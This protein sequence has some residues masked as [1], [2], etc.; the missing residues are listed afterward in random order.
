MHKHSP[1]VETSLLQI[2]N[3]G[4]I[5]L[6]NNIIV[7]KFHLSPVNYATETSLSFIFMFNGQ[8]NK[9]CFVSVMNML[10]IYLFAP[11]KLEKGHKKNYLAL[12]WKLCYTMV[13]YE[14]GWNIMRNGGLN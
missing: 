10:L 1:R 6:L 14:I 8:T 4:I 9:F 3:T 13:F 11:M 12:V 5:L 7:T 2:T